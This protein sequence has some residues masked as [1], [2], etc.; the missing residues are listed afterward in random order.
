MHCKVEAQN[1]L[2]NNPT[3]KPRCTCSGCRVGPPPP[4]RTS[5]NCSGCIPEDIPPPTK[6]RAHGTTR[7]LGFQREVWRQADANIT[8]FLPPEVFFPAALVK[9]VLDL[10][11]TFISQDDV[12]KLLCELKPEFAKIAADRK[13]E[14]AAAKRRKQAVD[15]DEEEE[16]NASEEECEETEVTSL[17]V[18]MTASADPT[19]DNANP[20]PSHGISYGLASDNELVPSS[21][22]IDPSAISGSSPSSE[23]ESLESSS[24]WVEVPL[25]ILDR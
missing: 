21:A 7:L 9:L 17:D 1:R 24:P 4:T 25:S 18:V 3:S 5:C 11:P 6:P 12:T 10:Y 19:V 15:V 20:A 8:A 13:A 2:Y 23:S 16:E 14:L 22:C